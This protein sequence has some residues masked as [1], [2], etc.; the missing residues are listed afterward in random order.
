LVH[1]ISSKKLDIKEQIGEDPKIVYGFNTPLSSLP[2][3][4]RQKVNKEIQG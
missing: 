3:S 1:T 2:R 4:S